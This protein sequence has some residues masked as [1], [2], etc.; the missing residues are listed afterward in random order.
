MRRSS[1]DQTLTQ[2]L[3]H[4]GKKA[5]DRDKRRRRG[6]GK[7]ERQYQVRY[8]KNSEIRQQA[9]AGTSGK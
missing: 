7:E 3:P 5:S 8:K 9:R 6:W 4:N 2:Q 1:L